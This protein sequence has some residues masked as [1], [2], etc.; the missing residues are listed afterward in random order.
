MSRLGLWLILLLCV[1]GS[2]AR[3]DWIK[4]GEKVELE[5]DEGLV[6]F[7]VD[8]ENWLERIDIDR[9][10][11][12]FSFPKLRNLRAGY[13]LRVLVLPAGDYQFHR[14]RSGVYSWKL[15]ALPNARFTVTAGQLNYV[16]DVTLRGFN[17]LTLSIRNNGLQTRLRLHAEF[18]GLAQ[19][20]PWRFANAF[21]D[22]YME[23]LKDARRQRPKIPARASTL[24]LEEPKPGEPVFDT[25][26]PAPDGATQG[27]ARRFFVPRTVRHV[28]LSPS[29][30]HA[31]EY[32]WN[33]E[34]ELLFVTDLKFGKSMPLYD[35]DRPVI[36]VEWLDSHHLVLTTTDRTNLPRSH[37]VT[38]TVD[39][40]R[41]DQKPIPGFG[42]VL[43]VDP[44]R[45][46]EV[47]WVALG[48]DKKDVVRLY[49]L[50]LL[51]A[52]T[53][54][55]LR[56]ERQLVPDMRNDVA[57]LPDQHGQLRMVLYRD[58]EQ[59]RAGWF[60][61]DAASGAAMQP[62]VPL[63]SDN[64]S[65]E[66]VG[67]GADGRLLALTDHQ[68]DV[69]E[70][71]TFDP[72]TGKLGDT[73][74]QEAGIDLR[75]VVHDS[76]R[77][78]V[79][80]RYLDRGQLR[81]KLFSAGDER[82]R[83]ALALKLPQRWIELSDAT[84]SHNRLVYTEGS[85]DAGS[86]HVHN[87]ETREL[88]VLS[89]AM[90]GLD[91]VQLARSERLL[92]KAADGFEIEAFLTRLPPAPGQRQ[93]LLVMPHGGP[94]GIFDMDDF[95]PEVQY[96]AQLGYAV[97]RVNFRGSGHAGKESLERGLLEYGKG[98]ESDIERV[99]D[100]VLERADLDAER[101]VALGTSYGGYSAMVLALKHP[102][103]YRASVAIAAPTDL[104]LAYTCGDIT[105]DEALQQALVRQL[106]DPRRGADGH[107]AISPV[108]R[109]AE[110][111]RPLL[112]VHDHGDQRVPLEHVVRLRALLRVARGVE[113]PLIETADKVH[114]LAHLP[115]AVK[116]WP[117]IAAFLDQVLKGEGPW[118]REL[119]PT[120]DRKTTGGPATA[121]AP[122]GSTR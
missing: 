47:T 92:V 56:P 25:R 50:N 104:L 36:D 6:V 29:G 115:T 67:F 23:L 75:S 5:A 43:M 53:A 22:D 81:Q 111:R 109:H 98:I 71:V 15:S 12:I 102:G 26:L 88:R 119:A 48:Q 77:T 64:A 74:H 3:A 9:I 95:S 78:V 90:P 1:L 122:G 58:K 32:R 28:Q 114:G 89:T 42:Y 83:K 62:I 121:G 41:V 113:L 2:A 27:W 76:G 66:P 68:R 118:E 39:G 14:A 7:G 65:F 70:L 63:K 24:A 51:E 20:W 100:T 35:G 44:R 38:L 40:D 13:T 17:H 30:Q 49:R 85:A 84:P 93:P 110:I 4:P 61:S 10:G 120:L 101:V 52:L 103:R 97:L 82:L 116:V 21:P 87:S 34:R 16:G 80:V 45:N 37:V 117:R 112:L 55:S 107:K 72:L 33:K 86:W 94:I 108:Y 96:F 59:M 57:W 69:V 106:G 11:T 99:V 8:S 105:D 46:G 54:D 60:Q 79:G 91:D 73:V 31:L 18:P 19:R